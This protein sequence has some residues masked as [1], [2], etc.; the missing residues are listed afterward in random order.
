ML[1]GGRSWPSERKLGAG[2]QRR[3]KTAPERFSGAAT[4]GALYSNGVA[5]QNAE[6]RLQ[7][8]GTVDVEVPP[9]PVA[10]PLAAS[11]WSECGW[12]PSWLTAL[13]MPSWP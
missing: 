12:F 2:A 8:S 10:P 3:G 4:A 1:R 7:S 6:H 5:E 11:L 13:V 9:S